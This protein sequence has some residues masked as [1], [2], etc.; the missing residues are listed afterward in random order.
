MKDSN[1]QIPRWESWELSGRCQLEMRPRT[2][3]AACGL[4]Y[5]LQFPRNAGNGA[6]T[7]EL[8]RSGVLAHD[9]LAA[10]GTSLTPFNLCSC[11]W[12]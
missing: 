10:L 11:K 7:R 2:S 8:H 4:L 1:N 6:R 3:S 12:E 9:G 5:A